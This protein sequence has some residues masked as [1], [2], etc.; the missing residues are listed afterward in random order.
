M[1]ANATGFESVNG[2]GVTHRNSDANGTS[3]ETHVANPAEDGSPSG[4]ES[5]ADG[6]FEEAPGVEDS[7]VSTAA[8]EDG[9]PA[10]ETQVQDGQ[11]SEAE[12]VSAEATRI[13]ELEREL[14]ERQDV[15]DE[16]AYRMD[17]DPVLRER[18]SSPADRAGGGGLMSEVESIIAKS[19]LTEESG[20]TLMR[21]LAP[22][23]TKIDRL[24]R[25][26]T[27][28]VRQ[29]VS[30]LSQTI[31]SREFTNALSESVSQADQK[32]QAFRKVLTDLRRNRAFQSLESTDPRSAA[33][34]VASKWSASKTRR[35][36]AVDGRSRLDTARGNRLTSSAPRGATTAD[37]IIDV[38]REGDFIGRAHEIR[39]KN[40]NAKIRYVSPK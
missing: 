40:P 14:S 10:E 15:L 4:E 29:T 19:D 27:G 36:A 25:E 39:L 3:T 16:I 26:L 7:S 9:K 13:E 6:G 32:N 18:L 31:G 22:V 12:A 20:S 37:K 33:D 28:P 34:Y 24:E 30:R 23:L 11:E 5:R 8:A 21:A 2:N 1:S 17:R 35:T 38:T